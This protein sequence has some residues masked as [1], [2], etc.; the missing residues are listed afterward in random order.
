MAFEKTEEKS[1]GKSTEKD[2]SEVKLSEHPIQI[3]LPLR[4]T[5]ELIDKLLP[6][7]ESSSAPAYMY[8]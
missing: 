1:E 5:R 2:S 7:R 3:T 8:V 6:E 4:I